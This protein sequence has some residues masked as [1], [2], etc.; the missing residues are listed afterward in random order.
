[1][2]FA[3]PSQRFNK[4][5][6]F[7]GTRASFWSAGL[8]HACGLAGMNGRARNILKQ[9]LGV[10][11]AVSP[12]SP[13]DIA[14][15]YVGLGEKGAA[16]TWMDKAFAERCTPLVYQNIEPSNRFAQTRDFKIDCIA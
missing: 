4:V 1:M 8:G 7:A 12:I 10:T 6:R 9:L 14:W 15:V 5:R 16:L 11:S 2:C 3:R 13:L